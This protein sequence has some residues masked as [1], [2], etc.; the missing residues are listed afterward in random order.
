MGDTAFSAQYL[1]RPV[2]L[3][4][5]MFKR[6]WLRS[7]AEFPHDHPDSFLLQSWDTAVT[8][9]ETSNWSVC[10]TWLINGDRYYLMEVDRRRLRFP[11][12]VRHI[13]Y[14]RK[15][16]TPP[17]FLLNTMVLG[18]V[19]S[20][21][22][23]NKESRSRAARSRTTRSFAPPWLHILRDRTCFS[24]E[25]LDPPFRHFLKSS[26]PFPTAKMTTRSTR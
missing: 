9:N 26:S 5:G 14:K 2:P 1:Q 18:L 13:A 24:A 15:N 3:E 19:S 16:M 22:W 6:D 10:T 7:A 17:T 11:E 8:A 12:L 20:T 25:N 23:K 21:S 4:G